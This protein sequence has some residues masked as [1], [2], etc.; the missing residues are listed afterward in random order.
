[1]DLPC[2]VLNK[3]VTYLSAK[4]RLNCGRV[5]RSWRLNLMNYEPQTLFLHYQAYPTN[6]RCAYSNELIDRSNSFQIKA[7]AFI[8]HEMT[9]SYFVNIKKLIIFKLFETTRQVESALK[10]FGR[11]V[12]YFDKLEHLEI[13]GLS[14]NGET[15]LNLENLK[16]LSLKALTV[17]R[18]EL[19]TPNLV[20]LICWVDIERLQFNYPNRLEYLEYKNQSNDF[21]F[22]IEFKNVTCLNYYDTNRTVAGDFLCNLPGLKRLIFFASDAESRMKEF[23]RQKIAY[24]LNDLELSPFGFEGVLVR[25][26]DSID[27]FCCYMLYEFYLK[28]VI[29]NYAKLTN[30]ITW[31]LFVDYCSLVGQFRVIPESFF[32][33]FVDF[34]IVFVGRE[35]ND[36]DQLIEFL[37]NCGYV[38]ELILQNAQLEQQAFYRRLHRC[39]YIDKLKIVEQSTPSRTDCITDYNFLSTLTI[40]ELHFEFYYLPLELITCA[41]R[42]RYIRTL[43]FR[44][45]CLKIVITYLYDSKLVLNINGSLINA[46]SID[47]VIDRLK[48]HRDTKHLLIG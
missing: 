19:E 43:K 15:K 26:V 48:N 8:E 13:S 16:T 18:L 1:M 33:K 41:F 28:S 27:T 36:T 22:K 47:Q 25:H 11:S 34:Y 46:E 45:G 23:N 42:N 29:D 30:K 17:D 21:K 9:R 44:K 37:N 6:K 5:C 3:I 14:L 12:S 31:P 39:S 2:L 24:G 38:Y 40:N 20:N 7:I 4:E 35:I 32:K 10:D